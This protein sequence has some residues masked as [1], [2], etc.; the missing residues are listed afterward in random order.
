LTKLLVIH[1]GLSLIEALAAPSDQFILS[2]YIASR[3]AGQS[4]FWRHGIEGAHEI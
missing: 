1:I 2:P 3:F 4:A